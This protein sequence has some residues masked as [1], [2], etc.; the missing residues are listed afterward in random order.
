MQLIKLSINNFMPY[1]GE[2]VLEFP[3]DNTK[4]TLVVFGDNMRGKTS[5]LNAIRWALYGK[6]I[7]RHSK[8]IPLQKLINIEAAREDDWVME[9]RLKF[10][11]NNDVYDLTRIAKKQ[12]LVS[13]PNSPNDFRVEVFLSINNNRQ[14]GDKVEEIINQVLPEEIS[15]FFLFDGELLQEY[16]QL[17]IE[18]SDQGKKIKMAIEQAMGVPYITNSV[19]DLT[20]AK[21]EFS[22]ELNKNAA[23]EIGLRA[24]VKIIDDLGVKKNS[25]EQNLQSLTQQLEENKSNLDRIDT[26]ISDLDKLSGEAKNLSMAE[27]NLKQKNIDLQDKEK[28][29]KKLLSDFWR[30]LIRQ[31]LLLEKQKLED[32][33]KIIFDTIQ[34]KAKLSVDVENL[35][36]YLS[37]NKCPTCQQTKAIHDEHAKEEELSIKV[38]ELS[39]LGVDDDGYTS[40]KSKL[41]KIDAV[42]SKTVQGEYSQLKNDC[43]E[44]NIQITKLDREIETH[45]D[46]LNGHDHNEIMKKRKERDRLVIELKLIK[47]KIDVS[48]KEINKTDRDIS[49]ESTKI[50]NDS[51]QK[52]N[53]LGTKLELLESLIKVFEKSKERLR[54]RFKTEVEKNAT[55]TFLQLSTQETYQGLAINNNYGLS[56]VDSQGQNVP[57]RSAG[58]EQIVALSLIDGLSKASRSK[59]PIVMD[60]PF[61]RL[62]TKHRKNILKFLPN[63]ANQLVLF[64]HD[65]EIRGDDDLMPIISRIYARYKIVEVSQFHSRLER[66]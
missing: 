21:S 40:I 51:S 10:S 60:T 23:K 54:D 4:N 63:S 29:Q 32:E 53:I 5:L 43:T 45:K 39:S 12:D 14:M 15:R 62:D 17:L 7:D 36:Q 25:E 20:K 47:D 13:T 61:G 55:Q 57:L 16:E 30:D 41:K 1:K 33:E 2:T 28:V 34:K 49:V 27:S 44:I 46:N 24:I 48:E 42:L 19:N 52:G 9:S 65:G 3:N 59:G 31:K 38:S 35:K 18:D 8:I 50:K 37:E 26:Q 56:I 58:A 6:A 22:T 11:V 64:V 66:I